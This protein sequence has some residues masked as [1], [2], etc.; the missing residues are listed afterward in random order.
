[1]NASTLPLSRAMRAALAPVH[2]T[3]FAPGYARRAA[4]SPVEDF[5]TAI[6]VLGVVR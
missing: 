5:T 4:F 2:R 6:R 3:I 1:M